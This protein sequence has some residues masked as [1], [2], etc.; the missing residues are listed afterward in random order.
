MILLSWHRYYDFSLWVF[1][2]KAC[3]ALVNVVVLVDPHLSQG[4]KCYW[5]NLLSKYLNVNK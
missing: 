2:C 5:K 3:K 4:Q 1:K